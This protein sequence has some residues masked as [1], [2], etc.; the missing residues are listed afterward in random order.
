MPDGRRA[1]PA[2]RARV[3]Q[4]GDA[5]AALG[6][7]AGRTFLWAFLAL[8]G[9]G[10]GWALAVPYD[11]FPDEARHAVRAW[12]AA[13]GEWVFHGPVLADGTPLIAAPRSLAPNA[14]ASSAC[15]HQHPQ[16]SAACSPPAGLRS[17][18]HHTVAIA[19]GAGRYNPLYYVIVGQPLRLWPTLRGIYLARMLSNALV[20]ALFATSLAV[21]R[22]ARTGRRLLSGLLVALTPVALHLSSA[23]NPAGVEI[24][25]AVM[26]WSGLVLVVDGRATSPTLIRVCG[27]GAAVVATV[28][29]GGVA[30]LAL[31]GCVAALGL[32]R[33]HA[34]VLAHSLTVRRWAAVVAVALLA[35]VGWSAWQDPTGQALSVPPGQSRFSVIANTLNVDVWGRGEYLVKGMVGLVGFG[36]TSPPG[37]VFPLWFCACGVILFGSVALTGWRDRARLLLLIGGTAVLTL[38]ADA[39]PISQGWYLS[40]GRYLLPVLAGV[41]ILGSY[42]LAERG[43]LDDAHMARLTRCYVVVLLPFQLITLYATMLR[44]QRGFPSGDP[45]PLMPVNPFKGDW[46][47]P[48]GPQL[49]LVLAAAGLAGLGALIWRTASR[50]DT[51]PAP[52][53]DAVPPTHRPARAQRT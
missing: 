36:D 13:G 9:L 22:T 20:S 4:S 51:P 17:D 19:S 42:L 40:Q 46:L 7:V 33:R 21:A 18:A 43:I 34:R 47:P 49:P 28:R 52:E 3:P 15:F 38:A 23:I 35:G 27:V 31:I 5:R 30:W 48:L 6:R 12:S 37:I 24:A 29:A 2:R 45:I 16:L 8:F 53:A 41:P 32:S 50:S 39:G 44:Y 26:L 11:G 14:P 25:A 10:C 1:L